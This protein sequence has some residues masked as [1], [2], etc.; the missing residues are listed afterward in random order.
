MKDPKEGNEQG[1]IVILRAKRLQTSVLDDVVKNHSREALENASGN[2]QTTVPIL[3][4]TEV[5]P[6][7][8]GL[9]N[10]A[11]R[12]T[13]AGIRNLEVS[14]QLLT[15]IIAHSLNTRDGRGNERER[16]G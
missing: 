5:E 1:V 8:R 9:G 7:T 10:V 14:P 12:Q 11:K 3:V 16:S 2:G 4:R 13:E 6:P 15:A